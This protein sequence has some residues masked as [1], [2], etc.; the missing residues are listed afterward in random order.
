MS[1]PTSRWSMRTGTCMTNTI[2][3]HMVRTGMAVSRMRTV[4]ATMR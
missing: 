1:T 3:M 2:G 4:I